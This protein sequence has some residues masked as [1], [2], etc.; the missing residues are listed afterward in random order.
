MRTFR[1]GKM[2]RRTGVAVAVGLIAVMS[3]AAGHAKDDKGADNPYAPR[4]GLS[5][6]E[7]RQFIERM[8]DAPNSIHER[9]G[10]SKGV[11]QAAEQLLAG[12]PTA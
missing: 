7:L 4:K 12:K 8:Q 2:W 3:V 11:V 9:P 10:Y 1:F 6:T 5:P